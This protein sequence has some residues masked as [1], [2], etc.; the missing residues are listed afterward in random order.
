[1]D[2]LGS[3]YMGHDTPSLPETKARVDEFLKNVPGLVRDGKIRPLPIRI[4]KADCSGIPKGL[5]HMEEGKVSAANIVYR[6]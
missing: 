4:W 5:Q 2:A 1:M 3:V 6:I